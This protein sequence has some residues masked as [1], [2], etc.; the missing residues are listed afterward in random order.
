MMKYVFYAMI[1]VAVAFGV[2]FFG[3]YDVPFLEIPSYFQDDDHYLK[4]RE[5]QEEAVRE[6]E[7][8]A[9]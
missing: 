2:E 1:V 8:G 7:E 6:I 4:G 9:K 5:R 3:I